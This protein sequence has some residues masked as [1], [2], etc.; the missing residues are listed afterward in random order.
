MHSL[1]LVWWEYF[2]LEF[3]FYVTFLCP[4]SLGL[5]LG[6]FGA[7]KISPPVF[8]PH[9]GPDANRVEPASHRYQTFSNQQCGRQQLGRKQQSVLKKELKCDDPLFE[10][11][12]TSRSFCKIT[13]R[14]QRQ[15]PIVMMLVKINEEF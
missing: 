9:N 7:Q 3:F 4:V 15:V 6:L 12:V 5:Y 2:D 11:F 14:I 10:S 1:L 13:T 8:E